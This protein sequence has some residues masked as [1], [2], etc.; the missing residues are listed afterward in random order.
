MVKANKGELRG[1]FKAVKFAMWIRD[2]RGKGR[3][4]NM[5][6]VKYVEKLLSD[7][8]TEI[9]LYV[10]GVDTETH[11]SDLNYS[12]E[13]A[14]KG[15]DRSQKRDNKGQD[16]EK[17]R[18]EEKRQYYKTLFDFVKN[19]ERLSRMM[20]LK[21]STVG[22][23]GFEMN[24][25]MREAQLEMFR[26]MRGQTIAMKDPLTGKVQMRKLEGDFLYEYHG[27]MV[28]RFTQEFS[29][30]MDRL[31]KSDPEYLEQKEQATRQM[32]STR[33]QQLQ[34]L[35]T[36]QFGPQSASRNTALTREGRAIQADF[37][38]QSDVGGG[39]S[40]EDISHLLHLG[41]GMTGKSGD[42]G[43]YMVETAHMTI[44][45]MI[46]NARTHEEL[47]E[48]E[49]YINDVI[50]QKYM[51]SF[52]MENSTPGY[53]LRK[54]TQETFQGVDEDKIPKTRFLSRFI[55]FHRNRINERAGQLNAGNNP[56]E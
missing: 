7:N 27:Q 8:D 33:Y 12:R 54:N 37:M 34:R 15:K 45:A 14:R 3:I 21:E 36:Q 30:G 10:K 28:E 29:K 42:L 35:F 19:N 6:V 4:N 39:M 52:E 41:K 24:R 55:T 9:A 56:I 38:L 53:V 23:Q 5:V 49:K 25:L 2:L 26:F 47:D 31:L 32:Y 46:E 18:R 43:Q 17:I 11:M 51:K 48:V 13:L 40:R 44:P 22:T 1:G 50:P 16:P 20:R